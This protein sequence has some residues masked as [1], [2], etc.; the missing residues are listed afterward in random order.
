MEGMFKLFLLLRNI[1]FRISRPLFTNGNLYLFYHTQASKWM[2]D[3]FTNIHDEDLTGMISASSSSLCPPTSGWE[4]PDSRQAKPQVQAV[5]DATNIVH[6]AVAVDAQGHLELILKSATELSGFS[7]EVADGVQKTLNT[8]EFNADVT[9]T[10]NDVLG[11][12]LSTYDGTKLYSDDYTVANLVVNNV[13]SITS[14]HLDNGGLLSIGD[15]DSVNWQ[16]M[17]SKAL[18][19]TLTTWPST[20]TSL[21]LTGKAD[22]H[23]NLDVTALNDQENSITDVNPGTDFVQTSSSASITFPATQTLTFTEGLQLSN[24]P[25]MSEATFNV[26]TCQLASTGQCLCND[27]TNPNCQ[28]VGDECVLVTGDDTSLYDSHT[29][30]LLNIGTKALKITGDQTVSANIKFNAGFTTDN[31][32]VSSSSCVID[33]VDCDDITLNN[34]AQTFTGKATI[35]GDMDVTTV[36]LSIGTSLEVEGTLDGVDVDT[37][38]TDT[39]YSDNHGK[40]SCCI[41]SF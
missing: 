9:V 14:L 27:C 41:S 2:V 29:E 22:F 38:Y 20:I 30:D 24:V 10:D 21:T 18:K 7:N 26:K 4:Y 32:H 3:W 15:S 5:N 33:G 28:T 34:M 39:L 11:L 6:D 13:D 8:A 23:E 25:A 1:Y 16:T 35:H 17:E 36:D 31:L 12:D 19:R 37:A 40:N